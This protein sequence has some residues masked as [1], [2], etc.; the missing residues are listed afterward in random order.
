MRAK[1]VEEKYPRYWQF[2]KDSK[3]VDQ[4][5]GVCLDLKNSEQAKYLVKQRNEVLDKLVAV[6]VAFDKCNPEE[7]KKV[8]YEE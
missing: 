3:S 8:W 1:Y 2:I 5:N 7:F 4:E 6:A